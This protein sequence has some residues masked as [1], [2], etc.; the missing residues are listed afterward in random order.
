MKPTLLTI[1]FITLL[2]IEQTYA[3]CPFYEFEHKSN[4]LRGWPFDG[5]KEST[6]KVDMVSVLCDWKIAQNLTLAA[7]AGYNIHTNNDDDQL[8]AT[9][10]LQWRPH[11]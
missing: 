9:F 7:G 1:I 5:R 6:V 8:I 3:S 2:G 4:L 10:R 11:D